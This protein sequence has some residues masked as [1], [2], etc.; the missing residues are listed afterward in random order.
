M[1]R[2]LIKS[3]RGEVVDFDDLIA[4]AS[5]K[6]LNKKTTEV[7]KKIKES[8]S[9]VKLRGHTPQI[10]QEEKTPAEVTQITLP[11][12]LKKKKETQETAN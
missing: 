3:A 5:Q 12:T 7:K 10:P 2:G 4:K 1:R 8:T 9:K 11:M 6:P